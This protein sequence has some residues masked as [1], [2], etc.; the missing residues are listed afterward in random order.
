MNLHIDRFGAWT[1]LDLN[2]LDSGITVLFGPNEAGKTTLL[3]FLRSMFYG[4]DGDEMA[5]YLEPPD[6]PLDGSTDADLPLGGSVTLVAGGREYDLHRTRRL[7]DAEDV[8]GHVR[9]TSR[10]GARRSG[11]HLQA[12]LAGT[13]ATIFQH[14]FA[15]GLKELQQLATLDETEAA[16]QL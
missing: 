6:R 7:T 4:Y 13:D 16:C 15:V 3:Q 2:H 8:Q 14:V 11:H 10:D 1:G 5:R 12:L 9:L